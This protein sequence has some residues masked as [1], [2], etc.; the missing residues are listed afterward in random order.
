MRYPVVHLRDFE[1]RRKELEASRNPFAVVVLAHLEARKTKGKPARAFEAKW[2]LT[3]R[4]YERG[5]KK[6]DILGLCGKLPR[7]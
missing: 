6:R 3:R 4:L 7:G 5:H 2:R 1:N